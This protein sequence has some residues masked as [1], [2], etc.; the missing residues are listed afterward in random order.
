MRVYMCVLL[1]TINY[2]M[3]DSDS[4]NGKYPPSCRCLSKE[5]FVH[6]GST[7]ARRVQLDEVPLQLQSKFLEDIGHANPHRMQAEGMKVDLAPLFK[8]VAGQPIIV[9]HLSVAI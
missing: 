9:R 2:P 4:N 6:Y 8:F 1:Y 3:Q 7:G 5:L